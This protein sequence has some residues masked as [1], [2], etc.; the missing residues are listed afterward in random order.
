MSCDCGRPP[1]QQAARR[2][3]GLWQA[4]PVRAAQVTNVNVVS[5]RRPGQSQRIHGRLADCDHSRSQ[6]GQH[7]PLPPIRPPAP[8][9]HV[10][11]G[12]PQVRKP[13]LVSPKSRRDLASLPPMV[14]TKPSQL[15]ETPTNR[16][17]GNSLGQA[18]APGGGVTGGRLRPRARGE[19]PGAV[20]EATVCHCQGGI[21][22]PIA[23]VTH[24]PQSFFPES[25]RCPER[26]SVTVALPTV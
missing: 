18:T 11:S 26:V 5:R 22:P 24:Q 23:R 13:G 21:Y 7:C 19:E 25:R 20:Q 17:T 4:R 12:P 10:H 1:F 2:P 3:D 15:P 9:G 6:S 14:T 8:A 16:R